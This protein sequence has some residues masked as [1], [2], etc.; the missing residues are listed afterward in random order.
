[1]AS[2]S[3]DSLINWDS[4][5]RRGK[6][7]VVAGPTQEELAQFSG[8]KALRPLRV[9]VGLDCG[10][11]PQ[12]RAELAL[13]ELIRVGAFQRSVLVVATPDRSVFSAIGLRGRLA[14]RAEERTSPRPTGTAR[15]ESIQPRMNRCGQVWCM[16]GCGSS[17]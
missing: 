12:E 8:R 14:C 4:I 13:A 5:G 3:P 7:F 16:C 6:A 2:G 15:G 9:Y 10:E 17:G 1:M 11:T